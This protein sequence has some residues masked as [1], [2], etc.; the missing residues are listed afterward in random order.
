GKRVDF[1]ARTVITA[2][3]NLDMGGNYTTVATEKSVA[4]SSS[5][6]EPGSGQTTRWQVS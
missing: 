2:D 3:P 1:S 5:K 6:P 4:L